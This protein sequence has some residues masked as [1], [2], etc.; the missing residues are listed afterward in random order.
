[1]R[2]KKEKRVSAM[3][4]RRLINSFLGL[5]LISEPFFHLLAVAIFHGSFHLH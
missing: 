3:A 4:G 5:R 1:M 2:K